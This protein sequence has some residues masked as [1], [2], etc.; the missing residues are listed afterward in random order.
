ML[1]KLRQQPHPKLEAPI[2]TTARS[3][4]S[5]L[6]NENAAS[7]PFISEATTVKAIILVGV[8]KAMLLVFQTNK[9]SNF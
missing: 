2:N 7:A 3:W 8:F 5:M 9:H 6:L 1:H 4:V